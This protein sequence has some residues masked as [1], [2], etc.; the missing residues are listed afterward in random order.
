MINALAHD[1][2]IQ[3]CN[4]VLKGELIASNKVKQACKRHLR[5]L[6]RIGN[7]DFPYIYSIKRANKV[8]DYME[9]LPDIKTGVPNNL[10]L[11][12]KFIISQLYGWRHKDKP[13]RRFNKAYISMARKNGKTIKVA[14]IGSYEFLFGKNPAYSRQIYCTANSKE[15]AK[16][17]FTM[18]VKQLNKVMMQSDYIRKRVRKVREEL[19][20][21]QSYSVLR[22][23]SKDTG[24]IDGFEPLIGILD[25]YHESKTTEMMEV[26]ESGQMLLENALTLIIST[27]GFNLNAP[28]Y[29]VEYPYVEKVL[30]GP[31]DFDDN[32][33][34][35]VAE[36]DDEKEVYD[37]ELWIKSNPLLEVEEL[38]PILLRNL[39]KKLKEAIEKDNINPT[40]VKNFNMW[41]ASSESS[42]IKEHDWK[43]TEK[44]VDITGKDVYI[45]VDLSRT[46]DLS[47]TSFISPVGNDEFHSDS[48]S[49][50]ATKG[51][52]EAKIKRDRID[53]R[54]MEELGYCTI[55]DLQTGVIN[56]NQII[57]YLVKY[58]EENQLTVKA[59][60]YDPYNSQMFLA[61]LERRKINWP[62]FEVRQGV[63]T[64]NDPTKD[65]R[66]Q[67]YDRKMTHA[68]NPL[69]DIAVRNAVTKEDNDT[70]MIN[71]K[72]NRE[73][74]D[75][76][77]AM[78]NAHTEAMYAYKENGSDP[79]LFF[80]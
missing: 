41:R 10:A 13:V 1:W 31:E 28:M 3:Y 32:Y 8:I 9:T 49:F 53:Y 42:Y 59:L 80:V 34:A 14:G 23:L 12:Q 64:L 38:K 71:K 24:S 75:P 46:D 65:Y 62:L 36:Q 17:A 54:K 40:L 68:K 78:V 56:F 76:I 66:K 44:D 60:C 2:S 77:V 73:K 63:K 19:T 22:P 57:D 37:E 55:T 6:E 15:Q 43:P 39:R 29:T 11:F 58:V 79:F 70:I 61:E 20:D 33:F 69:L 7:E 4:K 45:G 50:V 26:L 52:L 18:V 48:H 35:F 47:A 51:G 72:L 67:I 25:E 30:Y 16:I 27:A 21:E 74:I 5:D